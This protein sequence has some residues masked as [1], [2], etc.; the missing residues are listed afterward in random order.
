MKK[1]KP[2]KIIIKVTMATNKLQV[3]KIW[4]ENFWEIASPYMVLFD[5]RIFT[6]LL[7]NY[8][9]Q[10]KYILFSSSNLAKV[11]V[12]L[13]Y[14]AEACWAH[15]QTEKSLNPNGPITPLINA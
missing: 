14:I 5:H 12:I 1:I 9:H 8:L 13:S 7:G 10:I 11:F 2:V 6:I 15:N 4:L 3:E